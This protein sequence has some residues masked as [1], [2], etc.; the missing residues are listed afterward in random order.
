MF[1]SIQIWHGV[2][3][4][5]PDISEELCKVTSNFRLLELSSPLMIARGQMPI[6][7]DALQGQV[8]SNKGKVKF[9]L[10]WVMSTR[11]GTS[12]KYESRRMPSKVKWGQMSEAL[13]CTS[14]LWWSLNLGSIMLTEFIF[15][16]CTHPLVL[17]YKSCVY[18]RALLLTINYCRRLT[19]Q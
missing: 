16:L 4:Q 19:W 13:V 12:A 15:H 3:G 6:E 17:P 8:R 18:T 9:K 11:L 10:D 14:L 2:R 7:V 5:G 1:L